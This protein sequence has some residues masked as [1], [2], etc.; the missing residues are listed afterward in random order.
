MSAVPAAVADRGEREATFAV[1]ASYGVG[2]LLHIDRLPLWCTALALCAISWTAFGLTRAV[3]LPSRWVQA[4]LAL[5]SVGAVIATFRTLNGLSAGTAL[6]AAMGALKLLETRARRDR[7]IVIAATLFLLLAACLDRQNLPRVPLYLGEAWLTCAA[8]ALVATP[9]ARLGL[10]Q[11]LR[12]SAR[13]LLLALPLATALFLFFPRLTGS[14]W[15]LPSSEL[16]VTGLGDEMTPGSITRLTDSYESA[17]RVHFAGTVPPPR[18][19]YWRGPVLHSFDGFTWRRE[20]AFAPQPLLEYSGEA[21]RYRV[22]LEPN[23]HNWWFALEKPA[24]ALPANVFRTYDDMLVTALPIDRAVS[25]ELTSHTQWLT[26]SRLS[27]I[28]QRIDTRLPA[29]RNLR[30]RELGERLRGQAPNVPAFVEQVLDLFR[31]GGFEYTLSPPALGLDSVD[32]FIFHTKRGFCG[33]YA[34]AFVMLMRAGGVP[35]RVVTG[36]LG[37]EWNPI[38]SYMIVRQADAH[39]WA[40]IWLEER[41]WTRVDPTAVVAPARLTGDVFDLLPEAMSTPTRMRR[42]HAWLAK[43][44]LA[45][46]ALTTWWDDRVLDFDLRAQLD[47]LGR[48]GIQTPGVRELGLAVALTLALWLG[49]IAWQVRHA[50]IPPRRDAL[51]RAYLKLC[52]KLARAGL[53]RAAHEGPLDFAERIARERADLAGELRQ[54]CSRYAGLRFGRAAPADEVRSLARAVRDLRVRRAAACGA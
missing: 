45:G 19:R 20:R 18:A 8:L 50:L 28:E 51:G 26:T 32:D 25:Y 30:S 52:A 46:D 37:G 15:A 14:F 11:A 34:S 29:D 27:R 43:I 21:Y 35:A 39:A 44:V 12:L 41:G 7:L 42:T 17:F 24:S 31:R 22:T 40:E 1:L 48:L 38:G 53:A 23:Q 47:L 54:I 4:L 9:G 3:P 36:Y 16:A 33:H 10:R 5:A 2:L 6:L 13:S 49:W